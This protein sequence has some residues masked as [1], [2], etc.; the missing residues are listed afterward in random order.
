MNKKEINWNKILTPL[1]ID[2]L[3]I[4]RNTMRWE[5]YNIAREV[6]NNWMKF[7][8]RNFKPKNK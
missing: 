4:V 8:K 2:K 7:I 3:T 6:T 5:E 1:V